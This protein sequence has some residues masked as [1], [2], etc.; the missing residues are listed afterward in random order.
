MESCGF[1][2]AAA[3]AISKEIDFREGIFHSK[4][5]ALSLVPCETNLD[6]LMNIFGFGVGFG[7]KEGSIQIRARNA[8]KVTGPE[9]AAG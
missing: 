8:E 7:A 4:P 2:L 1:S 6:R 9:I 3:V 5:K